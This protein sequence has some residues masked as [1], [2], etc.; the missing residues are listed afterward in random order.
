VDFETRYF[1]RIQK[2]FPFYAINPFGS[3]ECYRHSTW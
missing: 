3:N 2:I 1:V